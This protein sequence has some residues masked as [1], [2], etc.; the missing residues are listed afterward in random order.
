MRDRPASETTSQ[1]TADVIDCQAI[2]RLAS[3]TT[4]ERQSTSLMLTRQC[5]AFAYDAIIVDWR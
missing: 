4:K 3:E 5:F 2:D 1:A